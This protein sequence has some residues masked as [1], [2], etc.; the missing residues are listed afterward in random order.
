MS[1]RVSPVQALEA[2]IGQIVDHWQQWKEDEDADQIIRQL[3]FWLVELAQGKD[4]ATIQTE[5]EAKR[6]E[7][8]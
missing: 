2:R 7:P 1:P 8:V 6:L 3:R 5:A 4:P